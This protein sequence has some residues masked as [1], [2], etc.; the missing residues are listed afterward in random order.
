MM[1]LL[2]LLIRFL[3]DFF[4]LEDMSKLAEEFELKRGGTGANLNNAGPST[5][6]RKLVL[7]NHLLRLIFL[8]MMLGML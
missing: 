1:L 4:D 7:L 8:V 3:G 6:K 2:L 5:F